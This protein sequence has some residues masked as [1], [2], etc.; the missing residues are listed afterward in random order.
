[1]EAITP[2]TAPADIGKADFFISRAGADADFAAVIGTILEGEGYRVILQQWDFANT[3][4][5]ERMQTALESGARVIALVSP[6]Y[7]KSD[8]CMA[9]ALN[10]IG[11][12][13]LNKNGRLIVMRIAECAPSGL[14]TALAYWDPL[15]DH[16]RRLRE[17]VLKAVD[18]A[19][20]RTAPS[21]F[22]ITP[23]TVLH[24]RIRAVPNFTGRGVDLAALD[25]ALWS[26][27]AAVIT[28]AS[29]QGLGGVGKSTLA[30]QYG[31][32]NHERYAGV[33]WLA[34]D[35][36]AGIIDG[37]V[38]L[39][40]IFILG[41]EKV[42]N[43]VEAAGA[44]LRFIAE[45]GFEKSWLLVYDNVE[46]PKALDGFL[47][48]AGAQVLITARWPDWRGRAAP[49]P[50]GVISADEAVEFLLGRTGRADTQ[51]AVPASL[52]SSAIS[53]SRSITPR[54]SAL[55]RVTIS[56]STPRVSRNGS[57]MRQKAPTIRTPWPPPSAP[58]SSMRRRNAQRPKS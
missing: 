23:K 50:L 18:R 24:D 45:G 6:A 12:D 13:P 21:S 28:Q 32:E 26:G 57:G 7:F 38:A 20:P 43:R 46:Q 10:T 56:A 2:E 54:R 29:V 25:R 17:I 30:I 4:F 52:T 16:A 48:R 41:L 42:E 14:L 36:Q 44:T 39:G 1:M 31:W 55:R 47:P 51:G 19:T 35:T 37:L 22:F 5:M 34:A 9:E 3:N 8:H 40:A 27:K 15:R 49:V 33:W 11:H 58:P 53:R